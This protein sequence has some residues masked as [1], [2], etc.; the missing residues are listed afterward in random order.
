MVCKAV[1][2]SLRY[3]ALT[4]SICRKGSDIVERDR[5]EN[6]LMRDCET[7]KLLLDEL[8]SE[9]DHEI[10]KPLKK[11]DFDKIEALAE[12]IAEISNHSEN[13]DSRISSGMNRVL[14]AAPERRSVLRSRIIPALVC[15]AL[16]IA[17][18]NIYSFRAWGK[19]FFSAVISVTPGGVKISFPD[20]NGDSAQSGAEDIFGIGEIYAENGIKAQLPQ[21]M[22]EGMELVDSQINRLTDLI[23]MSFRF[24]SDYGFVN[25]TVEKYYDSKKIPPILFP[26]SVGV[27][28]EVSADGRTFYVIRGEKSLTAAYCSDGAVYTFCAVGLDY[29]EFIKI[30]ESMK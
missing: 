15:F 29:D 17:G 20:V 9:L 24:E 4:R 30:A 2:Q 1:R 19:N 8:K 7:E 16:V 10:C 13:L 26:E 21:F 12:E 3:V 28:E 25:L 11:R 23:S 5:L 27:P 14:F 6:E 18:L 22:P